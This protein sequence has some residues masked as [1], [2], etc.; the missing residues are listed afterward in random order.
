MF[1]LLSGKIK[2]KMK[3]IITLAFSLV[4]F[5]YLS[6]QNSLSDFLNNMDT[7]LESHVIDGKV[8]Y[9]EV[10]ESTT[11]ENLLTSV[12]TMELSDLSKEEAKA[13]HINAYN[14][15]VIYKAAAEYPTPSVQIK[16]GFFERK[17]INVAGKEYSLNGYEKT[18]LLE[19]FKD[20]RLHF[21]LV[22]GAL[23]CPPIINQ[24]YRPSIL[25]SQLNTQTA[26]AIN[27]KTF[28]YLENNTLHVSQIFS[29]YPDDFG[30]RSN[31]VNYINQYSTKKYSSDTDI[32][33][34]D[35]NWGINDTGSRSSATENLGASAFRYVVSAAIP[36][37]GVELKIFN[38]LYS[39]RSGD[40]QT[41]N[42]RSS[43]FTTSIS[44]IYGWTNRFNAGLEIRFRRVLNSGL[45]SSPI[46]VLTSADSG[47]F[48]QGI[49][50]IGPRIR[51]APFKSL[52]NFSIQS[53]LAFPIGDQL[54]GD[55]TRPFID[56]NGPSFFTQLFND[57]TLN[58]KLS[59]F[60]ELDFI[61]EDIGGGSSVNRFSTPGTL[62]FSYFPNPKTTLYTLGQ[63]SP[64][65][66]P[67]IDYFWQI[68]LG[69]KYQFTPNFELELL[70]SKFDNKFLSENGGDAATYNLGIRYNY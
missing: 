60:T 66:T 27:D 42:T 34:Y 57:K 58:D 47:S 59:L 64:F 35:Y 25:D 49:T 3:N 61:L 46:D 48:R 54:S 67:E 10:K 20:A 40:G 38:N 51:F 45:P 18:E 44:A 63:Y 32:A 56:W 15:W 52:P 26:A 19:T 69:T 2:M 65:W 70:V 24:A 14:L 9:A 30:G 50:T 4:F 68:G 1:G 28:I 7:F 29:W 43:F 22:C 37:G 31:F 55:G 53:T 41:L 11:L 21:V 23:G 12:K 5:S 13:F 17:S 16:A 33:Y 39:Q 62:I 6:G 8:N 36:Q